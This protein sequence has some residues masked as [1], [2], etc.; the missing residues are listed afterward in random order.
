MDMAATPVAT[1]LIPTRAHAR[2]DVML[3][4]IASRQY[5]IMDELGCT[6]PWTGLLTAGPAGAPAAAAAIEPEP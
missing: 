4:E 3:I 6:L 1:Q 5:M 2:G